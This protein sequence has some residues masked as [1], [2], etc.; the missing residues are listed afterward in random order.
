MAAQDDPPSPRSLLVHDNEEENSEQNQDEQHQVSDND[1]IPSDVDSDGLLSDETE[2]SSDAT[3]DGHRIPNEA[4]TDEDDVNDNDCRWA[5][6]FRLHKGRTSCNT[7]VFI[8][9][10]VVIF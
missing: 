7:K 2:V 9:K 6:Y 4:D 1:S 3:T 10:K 5:L 8:Y